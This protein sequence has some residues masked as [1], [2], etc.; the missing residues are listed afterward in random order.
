VELYADESRAA[1]VAT[2]HTLRQQSDKPAGQTNDALADLVAPAGVPDWIG[3]FAVT[4][5]HGV[6]ELCARFEAEHDD[7]SSILV[8]ALADRLAEAFA[9]RLHEIAR[10]EW[11][12]GAAETLSREDLIR[13]R[14]R[15]I[16]PA[17]GYPACP[18]H[19]E[20]RTLFTLLEVPERTGIHLTESLAMTPAS[21]VCGLYFSHP[22]ARYF[23]VGRLGPDQLAD[24]ARRKGMTLEEASRWLAPNLDDAPVPVA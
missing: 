6:P 19:T 7:Y 23:G 8:K 10:V 1:R 4:T 15:G 9:E 3:A 13:E 16:R 22:E 21:S 12:F 14:Y 24:Y 5:G 17:P 2:L 11:G 20:K 18:D